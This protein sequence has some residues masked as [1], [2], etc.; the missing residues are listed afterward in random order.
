MNEYARPKH[1][2]NILG[3]DT[4][5]DGRSPVIYTVVRPM[6]VIYTRLSALQG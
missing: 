3:S 5:E 2:P 4:N 1:V 6:H